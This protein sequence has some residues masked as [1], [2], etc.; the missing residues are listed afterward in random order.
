MADRLW[1]SGKPQSQSPEETAEEGGAWTARGPWGQLLHRGLIAFLLRKRTRAPICIW[2]A[3][4]PAPQTQPR[5][6]PAP[7][8]F[9]FSRTITHKLEQQNGGN[10]LHNGQRVY[11]GPHPMSAPF[12]G[13]RHDRHVRGSAVSL[14]QLGRYTA[15]RMNDHLE[16]GRSREP[17]VDGQGPAEGR[18]V[19]GRAAGTAPVPSGST[20]ARLRTQQTAYS[21]GLTLIWKML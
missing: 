6:R 21:L 12:R 8:G 14:A 16:G 1:D 17:A 18:R 2:C 20:A 7:L 19:R 9:W 5:P 10:R 13:G 4:T 3:P 15:S 11:R